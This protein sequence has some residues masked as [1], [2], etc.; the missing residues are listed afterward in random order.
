MPPRGIRSIGDMI[1][2]RAGPAR[3][4]AKAASRVCGLP[5][6]HGVP[7]RAK[8]ACQARAL[9]YPG[10]AGLEDRHNGAVPGQCIGNIRYPTSGTVLI[11]KHLEAEAAAAQNEDA[12]LPPGLPTLRGSTAVISF[13][14]SHYL[15]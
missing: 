6:A 13:P 14:A 4:R 5:G 8:K 12:R 9:Q 15:A 11:G 10:S 3:G 2:Q 7:P 1:R